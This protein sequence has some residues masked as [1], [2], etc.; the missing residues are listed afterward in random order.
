MGLLLP[1][2]RKLRV[3]KDMMS[4][5]LPGD[6][7]ASGGGKRGDIQVFSKDA[8]YRLF[9]LLHQLEFRRV[10]FITL[11]YPAD[12]PT[13]GK[14][15]K[16]HLKEFRRRFEIE[17]GKIRAVWRLEFQERGA[18][19]YHIMFLDCPF[20]PVA[21]LCK[22]WHAVIRSDDDAH[23]KNGVDLKLITENSQQRLIACYV[24]KYISKIDERTIK[25]DGN[26]QGRYWGRWNIEEQVPYET[27]ITYQQSH[28]LSSF[29][30]IGR[31]GDSSWQPRDG[32]N[33]SVFGN[34]MGGGEFG[35][36]IIRLLD[37]IKK[38]QT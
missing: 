16:A 30:L 22:M 34:S 19:H 4:V 38:S 27:E 7:E 10:T 29:S 13:I 15:H 8:R 11:T 33:C 31:G 37:A 9:R 28:L 5:S 17:Y 18:P 3:W 20:I 25:D 35:T 2:K 21:W 1:H 24:G 26:K 32:S 23:L 6:K 36:R 12:F 14:I